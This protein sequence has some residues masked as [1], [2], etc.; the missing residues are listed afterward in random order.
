MAEIPAKRVDGLAAVHTSAICYGKEE[1]EWFIYFPEF[2]AGMLGAHHIT[3][4]S[5]GTI[6]AY[7]SIVMRKGEKKRHGWLKNGIFETCTDEVL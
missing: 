4:N 6:T 3:E 1:G 5:D 7:P 2:G